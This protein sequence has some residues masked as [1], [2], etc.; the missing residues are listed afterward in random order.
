MSENRECV[1]VPRLPTKEMLDTVWAEAHEENAAGA[2]RD[3]IEARES[4]LQ[5]G[6]LS[7]G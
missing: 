7:Q 4:S 3:M 2:W 6:E 1:L 5:Q